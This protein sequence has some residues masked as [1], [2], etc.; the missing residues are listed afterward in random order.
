MTFMVIEDSSP[1]IIKFIDDLLT[2][3]TQSQTSPGISHHRWAFRRTCDGK[4]LDK[5][6]IVWSQ[7]ANHLWT[8]FSSLLILKSTKYFQNTRRWPFSKQN[9]ILDL[10]IFLSS[11]WSSLQLKM[12]P[13][14]LSVITWSLSGDSPKSANQMYGSS[15]EWWEIVIVISKEKIVYS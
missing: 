6:V 3:I 9:S 4:S 12:R 10:S 5:S 13:T 7:S 8:Y 2:V 1:F 11:D 14:M 15:K